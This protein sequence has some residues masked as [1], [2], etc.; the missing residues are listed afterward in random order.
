M[1]SA[2]GAAAEW[3]TT[4][5]VSRSLLFSSFIAL[6]LPACSMATPPAPSRP[7]DAASCQ[8]DHRLKIKTKLGAPKGVQIVHSPSDKA[9]PLEV[10]RGDVI[11][12]HYVGPRTMFIVFAAANPMTANLPPSSNGKVCAQVADNAVIDESYK[13]W[14]IL[15]N[16]P[17]L[18]PVI[19]IRS[20]Q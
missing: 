3:G 17:A 7:L 10:R 19:I 2:A 1:S 18:D 5:D 11:E 12:W 6:I 4:M 20:A 8:A 14:V 13:Y 15:E 9:D 16:E